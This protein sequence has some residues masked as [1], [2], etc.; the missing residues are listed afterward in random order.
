MT[1]T[2]NL[3][4]PYYINTKFEFSVCIWEILMVYSSQ[5]V[6]KKVDIC[7]YFQDFRSNIKL[8]DV[9]IFKSCRKERRKVTSSFDSKLICSSLSYSLVNFYISQGHS[10]YQLLEIKRIILDKSILY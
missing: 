5:V 3:V 7:S 9:A 2:N 8:R 10:C 1:N 4:T 6:A